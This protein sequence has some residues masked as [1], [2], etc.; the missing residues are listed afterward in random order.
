MQ[1]DW[2]A[3]AN[4]KAEL[5]RGCFKSLKLQKLSSAESKENNQP[6]MGKH[7]GDY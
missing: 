5:W 6:P 7:G 1:L 3:H 2:L 4:Y